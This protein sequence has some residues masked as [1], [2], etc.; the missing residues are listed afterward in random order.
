MT[1]AGGGRGVGTLDHIYIYLYLY[2]YRYR[3][4]NQFYLNGKP[5]LVGLYTIHG[6][7]EPPEPSG[8]GRDG[9]V[10]GRRHQR[11]AGGGHHKTTVM[12]RNTSYKY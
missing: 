1:M 12:A 3:F 2:T 7:C 4:I 5:R 8:Q 6:V 10:G 11:L 9:G